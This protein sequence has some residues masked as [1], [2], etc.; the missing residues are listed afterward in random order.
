[1]GKGTHKNKNDSP[2][3]W[4][5]QTQK[6]LIKYMQTEFNNMFKRSY[7]VIKWISLEACKDCSIYES[8]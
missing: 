3:F 5:T 6:F 8:Q 7:T 2:V 4:W 1:M